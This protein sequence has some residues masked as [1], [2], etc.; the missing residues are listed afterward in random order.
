M[1]PDPAIFWFFMILFFGL[2]GYFLFPKTVDELYDGITSGDYKARLV[3]LAAA[4]NWR[5]TIPAIIAI[6]FF[7]LTVTTLVTLLG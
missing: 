7:F 5:K 2:A 6:A 4:I 1:K 3:N